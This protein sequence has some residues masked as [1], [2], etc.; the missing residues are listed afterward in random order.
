MSIQ[1]KLRRGTAVENNTFTGAEG[2]LTYSTDTKELRI[3]DGSTI[4]GLPVD[5]VVAWQKPTAENGYT[6]YRKYAS[7]WVEQG[8][9]I[10]DQNAASKST[11]V[12]LPVL[13]SDTNY[14]ANCNHIY[15]TL[16]YNANC[17][18]VSRNVDSF[19]FIAQ[20]GDNVWE[21]KGYA[22]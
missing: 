12:T 19:V 2:E 9:T 17:H 11:T 5:V 21:V 14:Y 15:A 18:L 6:W 16:E 3:H 7:G 13:M 1:L 20:R 10:L 22:A 8:G 4:G